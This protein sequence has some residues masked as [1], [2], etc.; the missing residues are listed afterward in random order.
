MSTICL[1]DLSCSALSLML[2][3]PKIEGIKYLCHCPIST[4]AA[5]KHHLLYPRWGEVKC[6]SQGCFC[7]GT[8]LIISANRFVG[9]IAAS[10]D[11]ISFVAGTNS[12]PSGRA[13]G[14]SR[15]N[16]FLSTIPFTRC[17][18]SLRM[19]DFKVSLRYTVAST[20]FNR[21]AISMVPPAT[22]MSFKSVFLRSTKR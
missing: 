18:D 7:N 13:V 19:A 20:F 21:S 12:R 9:V 15:R 6:R 17:F 4:F 10:L 22:L 16:G 5:T 8:I 14:P 2:Y 11:T 1:T 3:Y